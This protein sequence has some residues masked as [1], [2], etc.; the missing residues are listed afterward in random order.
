MAVRGKGIMGTVW[1]EGCCGR[2]CGWGVFCGSERGP[3]RDGRLQ[4]RPASR[5]AGPAAGKSFVEEVLLLARGAEGE[6]RRR[7]AGWGSETGLRGGA[8]QKSCGTP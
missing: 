4:Q 6:D 5:S 3:G 7:V 2:G 1:T 8:P